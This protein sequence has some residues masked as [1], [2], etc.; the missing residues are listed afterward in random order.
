MLQQKLCARSLGAEGSD[1]WSL[2]PTVSVLALPVQAWRLCIGM[3]IVPKFVKPK[4]TMQSSREEVRPFM[5]V[6]GASALL[7]ALQLFTE[8]QQIKSPSS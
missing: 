1:A 5:P 7:A 4:F 6:M 8:A 3:P 2:Q